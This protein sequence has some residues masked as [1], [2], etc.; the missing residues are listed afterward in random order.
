MV[1]SVPLDKDVV[2]IVP[3]NQILRIWH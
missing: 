1:I 3:Q 2:I